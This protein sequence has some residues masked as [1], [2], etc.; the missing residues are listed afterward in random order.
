MVGQTIFGVKDN[1]EPIEEYI[2]KIKNSQKYLDFK[3]NQAPTDEE[4]IE[5]I[6][7]DEV[8]KQVLK[9]SHGG[10]MY[11]VANKYNA[12]HLL[13][14][15]DKVKNKDS[16][17]GII[18]G[19]MN[20]LK[21]NSIDTQKDYTSILKEF[22]SLT[23]SNADL[24]RADKILEDIENELENNPTDELKDIFNQMNEHLNTFV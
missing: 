9:D 10:I 11:N 4:L 3:E 2:E 18:K 15:W 13:D 17:D 12:K 21:D 16:Q 7:S 23:D 5:Q 6:K 1:L 8:Y 19:A 14:L 24:D 22:L 20:F